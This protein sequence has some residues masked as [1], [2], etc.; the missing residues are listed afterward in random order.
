M[1]NISSNYITPLRHNFKASLLAQMM[2]NTT[3]PAVQSANIQQKSA[4]SIP[5]YVPVATPVADKYNTQYAPGSLMLA[6]M[7]KTNQT[8][9]ARPL[10]QTAAVAP[11]QQIEA[12]LNYKN[13]LRSMFQNNQAVI[14]ALLP[15]TFTAKD[16]DNNGL[17]QGNERPGYFTTMAERL[18]ELKTYGINT[19]HWLP[20]NPPGLK[21]A[22]GSA[23]SVYAPLDYL[24]I[25]PKL[26]D[27]TNPKNVYEEAKDAIKE[28]HKRDI[29]VMVDLPSCMSVDLYEARPDLRATDASGNPK[30]PEGWEDIRMFSPWADEDNKVLNKELYEYHKKFI[31]MCIDLG[32]DGIRADV[33]R[34]KPPEFWDHLTSYARSKDPEF[35]FLAECYTNEDASP[36]KNMPADRPFDALRAGFDAYYGQYHIFH[37]W[38]AKDFHDFMRESLNISRNL[39]TGEYILPKGK[40]LIGSFATHDDD[41]P[42]SHGGPDYC[43]MTNVIQATVPMTNPYIIS[44]F[45]SGDRY[46]YEYDK[47]FV[48]KTFA[49][50]MKNPIYKGSV[51]YMINSVDYAPVISNIEKTSDKN[52]SLAELENNSQY[53]SAIKFLI[54]TCKNNNIEIDKNITYNSALKNA[55]FNTLVTNILETARD[56]K[57]IKDL[58]NSEEKNKKVIQ[59]ADD[60]SEFKNIIKYFENNM[61]TKDNIKY[62]VHTQRIDIFNE[63]R[64][65][66]GDHPEIGHHFGYLMNCVRPKYGELITKGS[67]IPLKVEDDKLD[68]V[69]AYA[70]CKDGKTLIT[71]ANH[72]VNSR[73][74]VRVQIPG[75][76]ATQ[77]LDDL[78]PKYGTGSIWSAE[79]NAID[80]DLGPAQAHIFEVN[81]PQL[82]ETIKAQG[83]EVLQ[84]YL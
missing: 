15:R 65:P 80:I 13:N 69:I 55:K 41:S 49:Q 54:E 2:Q 66:K 56:Y 21:A 29:K 30:T 17:I 51:D 50:L 84:Q 83:S 16:T 75:L 79:N 12:P 27:P 44:G 67:Y 59:L 38:K 18:D 58:V 32:I 74:H 47:K 1:M 37:M 20:I 23:G 62:Y 48:D 71:I 57:N 77:Q 33:G 61:L 72:D 9:N 34:A 6:L 39:E 60:S 73:Q 64:Q 10:T 52:K 26:D 68:E 45:E 24:S 81:T 14:F 35:A 31:D 82:E 4:Q 42:M 53:S 8:S 11:V 19:L 70:R 25:D 40:S 78:S 76:A 63:S 22:K 28:C 3:V 46:L 5:A 36:M 43:M 7:N